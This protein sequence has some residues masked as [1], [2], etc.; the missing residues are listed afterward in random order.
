MT[1]DEFLRKY[2]IMARYGR[3]EMGAMRLDLC[4]MAG[5][6]AP[7]NPFD[8]PTTTTPRETDEPQVV[9]PTYVAPTAAERKAADETAVERASRP[10]TEPPQVGPGSEGADAPKPPEGAA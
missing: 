5:E 4:E 3:R 9:R 7:D 6:E 8:I 2:R 1:V 10:F